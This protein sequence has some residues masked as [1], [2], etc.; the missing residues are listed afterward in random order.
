M[1]S[2]AHFVSTP[3]ALSICTRCDMPTLTALDEGI[4]ARVDLLPLPDI[5]AEIAA[6]A[7]GRWT[8]VRLA[9]GGLAYR[10]DHRL[11]EPTPPDRIHAQHVCPT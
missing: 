8:Y 2:A 11:A 5:S 10:D 9:D 4:P 1:P 6:I 3:A 7:G